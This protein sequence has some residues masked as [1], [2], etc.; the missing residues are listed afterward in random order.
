MH[1]LTTEAQHENATTLAS[2]LGLQID[3]AAELLG[4]TVAIAFDR[5]DRV[6]SAIAAAIAELLVRTVREVTTDDT[7]SPVA[8]ELVIGNATARRQAPKVYLGVEEDAAILSFE[9]RTAGPCA[10]AHGILRALIACYSCAAILSRALGAELPFGQ[11]GSLKLEFGALGIDLSQLGE[12]IELG[13]AYLAG[14]GAIGNGLLWAARHLDLRGRLEICDDDRVSP[15]NLNRQLWFGREDIGV[16]KAERLAEKAQ[17][18]FPKL[19]LVPRPMRIQDLPEKS[20]GPWLRRLIVA[21]DSRRARRKLQNEFPGEIFDASTTDIR[22]VVVH[23][24]R[25]PTPHACMSCIYEPDGEELSR[26]QHIADHLGVPVEEVRSERITEESAGKI[27]SRFPSLAK[28]DLVGTAYDSLFKRLCGEGVLGTTSGRRVAAPFAFV[29]ALAGTLLALELVRRLSDGSSDR[30]FNYWRLSAWYSPLARRR[31]MRSR[32]PN[33]E[34][35]AN[36]L[37]QRVNAHLWSNKD[38][39]TGP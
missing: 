8:T 34:F 28:A 36:S 20:A 11:Q 22:E 35:C 39:T 23:H 38:D 6:A 12:P 19:Q 27:L 30:N 9:K 21:V 10:P 15:G 29:S 16:P 37:L 2:A 33:C 31:T 4:V 25:Q 1:P 24:N 5:E 3:E 14:A 7:S 13:H 32:Q 26:E 18:S 17:D